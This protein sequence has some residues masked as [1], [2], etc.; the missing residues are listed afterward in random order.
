[1]KNYKCISGIFEG[2]IFKGEQ[3][4]NRILNLNSWGQSFPSE[5]CELLTTEIK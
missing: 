2:L 3:S 5:N 1:M 4:G